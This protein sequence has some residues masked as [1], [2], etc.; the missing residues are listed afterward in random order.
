LDKLNDT[1]FLWVFLAPLVPAIIAGLLVGTARRAGEEG[2]SGLGFSMLGGA[3]TYALAAMAAHGVV[4]RSAA[5][6]E[7]YELELA[8]KGPPPAI[9]AFLKAAS[10]LQ[11]SFTS[12]DNPGRAIYFSNFSLDDSRTKLRSQASSS[13]PADNARWSNPVLYPRR[14]D[15]VVL[16]LAPADLKFSRHME[17]E[18]TVAPAA[19]G[20]G[21]KVS[22]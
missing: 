1:Y 12:K 5:L 8:L 20:G 6:A 2:Q 16:G 10:N 13:V 14:T 19:G 18:L 4:V 21:Q 3:A 11:I 17:A 15:A 22:R 7:A 9:E